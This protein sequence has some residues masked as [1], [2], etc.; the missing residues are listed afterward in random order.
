MLRDHTLEVALD[1]GLEQPD[2]V[3]GHVVGVQYPAWLRRDER[4][5]NALSLGISL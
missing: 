1:R 5:E 3:P 4:L 2:A